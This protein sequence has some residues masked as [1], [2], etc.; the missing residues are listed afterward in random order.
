[1]HKQ[2]VIKYIADSVSE[3]KIDT[4]TAKTLIRYLVSRET[5]SEQSDDVA[6]IGISARFADCDDAIDY[7]DMLRDEKC[8]V[9][10]VPENRRKDIESMSQVLL[11]N[12]G[13]PDAEEGYLT[14]IDEFDNEFFKCPPKA[15]A[16]MDPNQR[17]FLEAAWKAIEDAGY[18]ADEMRG[19]KTGVFI[20]YGS[21]PLYGQYISKINQ[22]DINSAVSGNI[23]SVVASRIAYLLDLKGPSIVIDTACSSSLVAIHL[24]CNSMKRNE[25]EMALAGG[26]K[27]NFIQ[28]NSQ[29]DIGINSQSFRT[30]AF[31]DN[32]DGTAWGE[33]VGAILLKPLSKAIKD[34]DHIYAVIKGSAVNQDGTSVGITAPNLE[35]QTQV[36]LDAWKDAGINP[37]QIGFIETHGTGTDLGDLIEAQ[38]IQR[39]FLKHTARK[40]FCAVGSVKSNIGHLDTAAGIAGF[41]KAVL[42]L[43]YKTIPAT[44]FCDRVNHKIDFCNSGIYVNNRTKQWDADSKRLCGVSSFGLSGTNCHIVLEEFENPKQE[45][46]SREE[47]YYT[48]LVSAKNRKAL[49]EVFHDYNKYF[50]KN[51]FEDCQIED[52]CFTALTGRISDDLRMA[53]IIKDKKEL[54]SA[55]ANIC[56]EES[57]EQSQAEYIISDG[58]KGNGRNTDASQAKDNYAQAKE[59]ALKYVKGEVVN[60]EDYYGDTKRKRVS[61]PGVHLEKRRFWIECK[62]LH[63][64]VTGETFV[65]A[66]NEIE[67]YCVTSEKCSELS[68]LA[69]AAGKIIGETLGYESVNIDKSF[70]QLG[71]DS[72]TAIKVC[73]TINE[74]Y[75]KKVSLQDLLSSD[76]I[77]EMIRK[78]EENEEESLEQETFDLK[79]FLPEEE[80]LADLGDYYP[81]TDVQMSYLTG[82]SMNLENNTSTHVYFEWQIGFP[83]EKFV[84]AINVLIERHAMLRTIIYESGTQKTMEEIPEYKPVISDISGLNHDEQEKRI[85]AK[86]DEISHNN[87]QAGSW[88]MF[89]IYIFKVSK[90]Q[91]RILS[92]L[93]MLIADGYSLYILSKE[94][95]SL[96]SQEG[97]VLPELKDTFQQYVIAYRNFEKSKIYQESEKFWLKKADK[98]PDYPDMTLKTVQG[99]PKFKRISTTVE[100]EVWDKIKSNLRDRQVTP[101]AFLCAVYGSILAYYSNQPSALLNLTL[102]NRIPFMDDIQNMIGDFTSIM[103]LDLYP[104]NFKNYW[105]YLKDAQSNMIDALEHRYYDGVKVMRQLSKNRKRYSFA[106]PFVFTSLLF[107]AGDEERNNTLNLFDSVYSLSETSQ[108]LLDCQVAERQGSLVLNWDYVED[109]IENDMVEAMH[110]MFMRGVLDMEESQGLTLDKDYKE[111]LQ[112]YNETDERID[113]ITLDGLFKKQLEK[114]PDK[115]AVR[116]QNETITYQELDKR[117]DDVAWYLEKNGIGCGDRV[118]VAAEREISSVISILGIL[119]AG[120][121][122]VPVSLEQPQKRQEYILENSGCQM[123]LNKESLETIPAGDGEFQSKSSAEKSAYIIYTSGS[124]GKPKGVEI[125]HEAASNTIQDI[126]RKFHVTEEDK[127]LGISSLS[128]DLSV[129]DLFGALSSGAELVIADDQRDVEHLAETVEREGITIWNSVPAIMK[130]TIDNLNKD[131]SYKELSL[132][133]VLLSGDWIPLKLPDGIRNVFENA[134]VISLGGATEGSIWSIYYPIGQVEKSWNSIPYGYPLANQKI[135]VLNFN[136]EEAPVDVPGEICIG[137]KGVAEGYVNEPEKTKAQFVATIEY[138]RIYRTG[139]YGVVRREPG[140]KLF[141]E[142]IGRKDNQVKVGGYRIELG[143]I[144]SALEE[145]HNIKQ[146]VVIVKEDSSRKQ[147]LYSYYESDNKIDTMEIR[148]FLEARLPG[149]M[150]PVRY[151]HMEKFPVTANGK[152]DRK[153][154]A[155]IKLQ[156]DK[157]KIEKPSNQ[158]EQELAAIWSDVLGRQEISVQDSFFELGGDSLKLVKAYNQIE[159]KYP[160]RVTIAKLFGYPTI[161]K[162]A[163]LLMGD[164]V[165]KVMKLPLQGFSLP[166]SYLISGEKEYLM[167]TKEFSLD[168]SMTEKIAALSKGENESVNSILY[169]G[170]VFLL[171]KFNQNMTCTLPFMETE[172]K[173]ILPVKLDLQNIQNVEDFLSSMEREKENAIPSALVL[174]DDVQYEPMNIEENQ[175][176]FLYTEKAVEISQ[177]SALE[178]FDV[179]LSSIIQEKE[180]I[181]IRMTMNKAR[182]HME[183][184]DEFI[185]NYK[186]IL[187]FLLSR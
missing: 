163:V 80:Q 49:L 98:L 43:K 166:A 107:N 129:Y 13:N 92:N 62:E 137:G 172:G 1:M 157:K 118:A 121:A 69:I 161:R 184:I 86:R 5:E 180:S 52:I 50:Q 165:K 141:V 35:S 28:D 126:N 115:A 44:L 55:I 57:L 20:G 125:R 112:Q 82:R 179:I 30:K 51:E 81:L 53:L 31:A 151:V 105:E 133:L 153:T 73:N 108:V 162:L 106:T 22:E 177:N 104:G 27:I 97:V 169:M 152:I 37:E 145:H 116:K 182:I 155:N 135:Y 23:T 12:K 16:L 187:E 144:E 159:A 15:A 46:A 24:A 178:V 40:Q 119:K 76:S 9:R 33:G 72:I 168:A 136:G 61:I 29:Y 4:G 45:S 111:K 78:L 19:T 140:G 41:I 42:A 89:E 75:D 36:L 58:C 113:T 56:R 70:Y 183:K 131:A 160:G 130:M 68:E 8:A 95:V 170:F 139:D 102:F 65:A 185:L 114:T 32:A 11:G 148:E 54:E 149:Y 181:S 74:Q 93:D 109:A 39:A 10:K 147:A 87:F 101:S 158:V 99:T 138:G 186:K 96:C 156:E 7:W 122:Y 38:A 103:L 123:M 59:L 176:M 66:G 71:G 174:K 142:F 110:R 17:L 91:H 25:C 47:E 154:I 100:K 21:W 14:H 3:N 2:E 117:S 26:I 127:I 132:R 67:E 128:Y 34:N 143:E 85:L 173:R 63:E 64:G 48:F 120:A 88:P 90:N 6:V 83:V 146:A 150:I 167:E 79:E 164:S 134:K 77:G 175:A 60:W 124:T 84:H 94:L 18:A 171:A